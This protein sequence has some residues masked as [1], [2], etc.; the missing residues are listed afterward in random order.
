[1]IEV[2]RRFFNVLDE[3]LLPWASEGERLELYH[4]GRSA[5]ILHHALQ[6]P[7][8]GTRDIDV[9]QVTFP[10]PPLFD[11][12]LALFGKGTVNADRLGLYLEGVPVGLPPLPGWF[13]TRSREA[14]GAWQVVRL[15][16]LEP[17]DLAATKLKSFRAQDREDLQ[18]LCDAGQLQAEELRQSLESAFRWTTDKDGD[19][20]RER[21]FANLDHVVLYLEGKTR[22]L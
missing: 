11:K 8:G 1:V 9:V 21:A 5:L 18:F 7:V 6:V 19:P 14:P 16:Q 10:C 3:E 22:S 2:I 15:W 20:D 4:I 13:A 12:A 17:H